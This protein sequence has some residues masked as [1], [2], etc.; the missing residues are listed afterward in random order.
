VPGS[1]LDE[2]EPAVAHYAGSAGHPTGRSL[3][4][5]GPEHNMTV[6]TVEVEHYAESG[7]DKARQQELQA[8]ADALK[9]VFLGGVK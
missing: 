2:S 1:H 7:A 5:W 3:G 8:H 6:I 4:D 9:D